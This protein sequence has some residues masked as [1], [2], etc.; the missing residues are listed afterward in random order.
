MKPVPLGAGGL[1][2]VSPAGRMSVTT[3]LGASDGP[4][5]ATVSWQVTVAPGITGVGAHPLVMLRLVGLSR[6]RK[7]AT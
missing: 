2:T 6:G 4:R 3:T 7:A 1:T 5:L